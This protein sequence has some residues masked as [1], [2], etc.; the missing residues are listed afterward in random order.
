[1]RKVCQ[2][3][4]AEDLKNAE[5]ATE[6]AELGYS[7]LLSTAHAGLAEYQLAADLYCFMKGLGAEDN[8]LLINA[9]QHGR[10]VAPPSGRIL[11]EGDLILTEITPCVGWQF[12]QICRTVSIGKPSQRVT[13]TYAILQTALKV[14]MDSALPGT[15]V[16]AT[17]EAMNRVFKDA[18][19]GSYCRPPY[20]RVRGHGL[21]SYSDLPGDIEPSN[22][23]PFA[24]N[25]FFVMHPNQYLPETGYLMCGEPV[26]I[27]PAGAF[28]L[29]HRPSTLDWVKP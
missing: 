23:T 18:G 27:T 22:Q 26:R 20:M 7:R 13:E 28:P 14:G 1:M 21:G 9:S 2:I 3:R 5:R 24:E 29:T 16:A 4:S 10:G 19:Y 11:E 12:S 8:F 15:T 25:M 17:A 6:I